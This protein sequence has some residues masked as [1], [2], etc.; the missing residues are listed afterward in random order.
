M[1]WASTEFTCCNTLLGNRGKIAHAIIG[2]H[3]YQTHPDFMETFLDDDR[4]RFVLN[5]QGLFHPKIFLFE[6][7]N[8]DWECLIGSANFTRGAFGSNIEACAALG[9]G[10]DPSGQLRRR[11][12][13]TFNRYWGMGRRIEASELPAVQNLL[14]AAPSSDKILVWAL[15]RS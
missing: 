2:I 15:W 4:V 14:G 3:F 1:A 11:L 6:N 10:D 5:P 13:Q 7:N 8:T 9:H 12:D